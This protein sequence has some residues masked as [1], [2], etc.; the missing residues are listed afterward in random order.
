LWEFKSPMAYEV[1]DAPWPHEV[2]SDLFLGPPIMTCGVETVLRMDRK[3]SATRQG[4]SKGIGGC[5]AT[6]KCCSSSSGCETRPAKGEPARPVASLATVPEMVAA[7]RRHANVRAVG[8]RPRNVCFPDA[9]RAGLQRRQQ[10]SSA[11]VG[12]E[13]TVSGGV[14]DHS[15]YEEDGLATWEILCLSTASFD[16]PLLV[17]FFPSLEIAHFGG[18]SL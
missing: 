11:V 9:E 10:R 13:G 14:F 4:W 3:S 18:E 5:D 17:R 8:L 1:I 12:E 2:C 7:M 16:A 15:T 6:M